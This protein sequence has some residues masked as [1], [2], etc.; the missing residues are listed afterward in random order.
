MISWYF[1]RLRGTIIES[2]DLGSTAVSVFA[3]R[4]DSEDGDRAW[5]SNTVFK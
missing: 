4:E 1:V 3:T 5:L 2:T